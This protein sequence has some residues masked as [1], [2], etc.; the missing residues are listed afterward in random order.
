M[1]VFPVQVALAGN[2]VI[3]ISSGPTPF[4]EPIPVTAS[5]SSTTTTTPSISS[6]AISGSFLTSEI[7]TLQGSGF[8]SPVS[9][10]L[11]EF[12]FHPDISLAGL[13]SVNTSATPQ[14]MTINFPAGW[15]AGKGYSSTND[16]G[17]IAL[18]TPSGWALTPATFVVP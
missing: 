17:R 1:L 15:F 12:F 9:N 10:D 8:W 18:E 16:L 13:Y 6:I 4:T 2:N 7:I 3:V 11:V 5:D 14:T